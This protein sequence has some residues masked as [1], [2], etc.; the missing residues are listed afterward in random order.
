MPKGR[1]HLHV[2]A[3]GKD[4]VTVM[5]TADLPAEL[6]SGFGC[7]DTVKRTFDTGL[8]HLFDPETEKNLI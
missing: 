4:V 5:Q 2:N 6:R 8:M 3:N 1:V 7:G